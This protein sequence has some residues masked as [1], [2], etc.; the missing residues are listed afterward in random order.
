MYNNDT[1]STIFFLFF[2]LLFKKKKKGSVQ[3]GVRWED[4]FRQ[5]YVLLS[6]YL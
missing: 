6:V 5:G 4:K 1:E 2:F 3:Q